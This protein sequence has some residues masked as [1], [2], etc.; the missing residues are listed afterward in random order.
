MR[1]EIDSQYSFILHAHT[2]V[3]KEWGKWFDETFEDRG[4]IFALGLEEAKVFWLLVVLGGIL[5]LK[6]IL[7]TD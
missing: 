4:S 3:S 6:K 2:C 1:D 7:K 5:N